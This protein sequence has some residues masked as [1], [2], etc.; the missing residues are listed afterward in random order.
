MS[1]KKGIAILIVFSFFAIA[2]AESYLGYDEVKF[3]EDPG[4]K[5]PAVKGKEGNSVSG[6]TQTESMWTEPIASPTG[7][8]FYYTPPKAVLEFVENPTKENA[9][10]YLDWN[11]KRLTAYAKAQAVM[12]EVMKEEGVAK[13]NTK[14]QSRTKG[15]S[16]PGITQK[17]IPVRVS[18]ATKISKSKMLYF[19]DPA[20]K[21]CRKELPIINAFYNKHKKEIDIEGITLAD[22]ITELNTKFAFPVR[23]DR[24]EIEQFGITTYPTMIFSMPNGTAF[25]IKG[26]AQEDVL[27]NIW[28]ENKTK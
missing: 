7:Q 5:A 6:T 20:C 24:G 1:M 14:T 23:K 26:F 8:I 4:K 21:Y 16:V 11:K 10:A 12:E 19:I 9:R 27:E 28:K 18:P 15:K 3:F 2:F 25:G 17:Q 22:N 13:K